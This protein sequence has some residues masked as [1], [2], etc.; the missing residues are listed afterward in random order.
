MG[1]RECNMM[2]YIIMFIVGLSVY[3][4]GVDLN[5]KPIPY[6]IDTIK[7]GMISKIITRKYNQ[8]PMDKDGLKKQ[9]MAYPSPLELSKLFVKAYLAD[10]KDT[11]KKITPREMIDR[12]NKVDV[13]IKELFLKI[14]KYDNNRMIEFKGEI[15][16]MEEKYN[17]GEQNIYL[18]VKGQQKQIKFGFVWVD[19]RWILVEAM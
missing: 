9:I 12:L 1:F 5:N 4:H 16:P 2:K 7:K 8:K 3:V 6:S 13:K 10:D 19:E 18:Y 11:M 17:L 14:E 15:L